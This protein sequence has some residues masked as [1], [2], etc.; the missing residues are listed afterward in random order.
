MTRTGTSGIVIDNL[1]TSQVGAQML[2]Y[3]TQAGDTGVQASQS[4]P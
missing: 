3:S 4:N 2:Y 1:S